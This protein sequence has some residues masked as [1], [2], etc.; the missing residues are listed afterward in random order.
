[1]NTQQDF[2]NK[3]LNYRLNRALNP[4]YN[5]WL[6]VFYILVL[7]FFKISFM[8]CLERGDQLVLEA[9]FIIMM[10]L[11]IKFWQDLYYER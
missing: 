3:D 6:Y 5:F 4:F 10:F 11:S 2:K 7:I 8:T 1:M 9:L